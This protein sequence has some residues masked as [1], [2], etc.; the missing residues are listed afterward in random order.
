MTTA[1]VMLLICVGYSLVGGAF[2]GHLK[3]KGFWSAD[4]MPLSVFW[5]M[6]LPAYVTWRLVLKVYECNE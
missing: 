5:P 4:W 6:T 2:A 1:L 3:A